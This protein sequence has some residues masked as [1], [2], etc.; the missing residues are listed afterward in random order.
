[1]RESVAVAT[2]RGSDRGG[3]A[4]CANIAGV[5]LLPFDE[6]RRRLRVLGQSYVGVREI[7]V[8]RI[9]GS[10]DREGDFDRDFRPR[11][12]LSRSRLANL[13]RAFPDAVMPA[14]SVFEVGGAY[15]VEDGHHR[16]AVARERGAEFIDAEVTRLQTNY[17]VPPGVDVSQ[18]VHTEQQRILLEETGLGRARP[19]AV[20]EFTLLD[21][22]AQLCDIIKA[23]GY[24]LARQ[25]GAVP[26]PEK[27]AGDW[28][29]SVYLPALRAARRA[30]LPERM[31]QLWE[32]WGLTDAD[33]V[34]W[35]YQLRRDVRAYDASADFDAAARQ[36]LQFRLT[37][38][39]RR[40]VLRERSRPLPQRSD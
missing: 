34:L 13:R 8:E 12:R 3:G 40:Q 32:P 4:C 17:E 7:P 36:A 14:I 18:L 24:D 10:V 25:R 30:G 26:A 20:I 11:R 9:V 38:Q 6:T 23:H 39:K 2:A 5:D 31:A 1:M 33:L 37:R 22:Y 16:V 27:V 35:L 15:F 21:G 28:Y 29:D 19:E